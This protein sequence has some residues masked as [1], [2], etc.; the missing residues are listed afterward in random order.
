MDDA[1]A[2]HLDRATAMR[3]VCTTNMTVS[4]RAWRSKETSSRG[5]SLVVGERPSAEAYRVSVGGTGASADLGG[6]SKYSSET[7]EA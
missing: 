2:N 1:Q 6:S 4:R 3:D 7:L 5:A